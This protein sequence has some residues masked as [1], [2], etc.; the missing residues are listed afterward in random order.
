LALAT[1]VDGL[2]GR[3]GGPH[4]VRRDRSP[5][6][7]D[8]P[9][10]LPHLPSVLALQDDFALAVRKPVLVPGLLDQLRHGVHRGRL[11]HPRRSLALL[12]RP[13]FEH[14]QRDPRLRERAIRSHGHPVEMGPER[15]HRGRPVLRKPPTLTL[16]RK[17]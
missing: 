3:S 17:A 6:V 9:W 16:P 5:A 15:H 4:Y 1:G 8:A 11:L 2:S 10:R 7:A 13:W 14:L 12:V